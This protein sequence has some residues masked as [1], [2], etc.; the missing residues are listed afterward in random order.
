MQ[1]VTAVKTKE[2]FRKEKFMFF[3]DMPEFSE[4]KYLKV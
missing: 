1:N 3:E 2:H 4:D